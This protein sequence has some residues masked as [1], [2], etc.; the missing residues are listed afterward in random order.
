VGATL[1]FASPDQLDGMAS[2]LTALSL[3]LRLR[4]LDEITDFHGSEGRDQ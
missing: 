1:T 4:D 3:D 2:A